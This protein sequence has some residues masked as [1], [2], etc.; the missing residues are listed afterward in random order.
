MKVT[1]I[2][3]LLCFIIPPITHAGGQTGSGMN[4]CWVKNI[5]GK[6]EWRSIE[7]MIYPRVIRRQS[8]SS[9]HYSHINIRMQIHGKYKNVMSNY[10]ASKA[11][12]RLKIIQDS[13]P[14]SYLTF[15]SLFQLFKHVQVS[16][17]KLEG[18]FSGEATII[19]GCND[20][21][22]AMMTFN[23]GAIVVFKPVFERL[24]PFSVTLLYIHETIRFAQVFHPVFS[25]LSDSD[26][27]L[28]TSLFFTNMVQY[29]DL[30]KILNKYEQR[31][32]TGS[33]KIDPLSDP[34]NPLEDE[35][36]DTEQAF[37]SKVR[38]VLF[39]DEE[40][41][42]NILNDYR[43]HNEEFRQHSA[44]RTDHFLQSA[45]KKRFFSI[46]L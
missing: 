39:E 23:D 22:P 15:L 21:S 30:N 35:E 18:L 37:K 2:I 4:G 46:R 40:N 26:L 25:D 31:L 8:P 38:E 6:L 13:H 33:Y 32:T 41:L 42:G 7:E 11:L 45:R 34:Y 17:F 19:K 12:D 36:Y 10:T 1:L 27:Q 5:Y 29:Q 14:K 28:L 24:D 3:L 16:K 43:I 20:Y 44:E 9:R